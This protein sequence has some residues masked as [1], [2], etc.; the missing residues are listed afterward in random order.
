MC[1]EIQ[2]SRQLWQELRDL[3]VLTTN[4][5]IVGVPT[6][7][8]LQEAIVNVFADRQR[9]LSRTAAYPDRTNKSN[10]I[11]PRYTSASQVAIR[12]E[13]E[14]SELRRVLRTPSSLGCRIL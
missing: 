8:E 14:A 5:F 2:Q 12:H 13:T 6:M 1:Q 7:D 11:Q 4:G 9:I 3:N 10:K